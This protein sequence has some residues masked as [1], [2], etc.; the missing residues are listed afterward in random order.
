MIEVADGHL[1][2]PKNCDV[3]THG[4]QLP[5]HTLVWEHPTLECPIEA[6]QT[7]SFH[8]ENGYLRSPEMKILL[9]KGKR[10]VLPDKCPTATIY[11]TEY[12]DIYLASPTT[13]FPTMT[14]D[15]NMAD[16]IA[17]RDDYI[18]YESE[19]G[20]NLLD[21]NMKRKMCARDIERQGDIS[22]HKSNEFIRRNSDCVEKF[23][24]QGKS[25]KLR[26]KRIP[27]TPIFPWKMGDSSNHGPGCTPAI[28]LP[29]HATNIM[30]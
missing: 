20:S 25:P 10:K 18:L 5:D 12:K 22:H 17:S 24:C 1:R 19:R 30:D 26:L 13:I 16:Y 7:I 11:E 15:M 4:C 2:L 6:V 14:D 28:L 21:K 9:K 29:V 27:V 23:Q 3:N 8:N